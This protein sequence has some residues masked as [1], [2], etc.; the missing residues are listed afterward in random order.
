MQNSLSPVHICMVTKVEIDED[1][2][3]YYKLLPDIYYLSY[4]LISYFRSGSL[5][6]LDSLKAGSQ[7][8]L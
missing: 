7:G 1:Y 3:G 5:E 8:H 6:A 4:T 2:V